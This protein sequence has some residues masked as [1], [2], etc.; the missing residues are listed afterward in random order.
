MLISSI[1]F[2]NRRRSEKNRR[3]KGDVLKDKAQDLTYCKKQA[4]RI[5]KLK[6]WIQPQ[7]ETDL[8]RSGS[9]TNKNDINS[10]RTSGYGSSASVTSYGV[11]SSSPTPL[12]DRVSITT[13]DEYNLFIDPSFYFVTLRK[14]K[15]ITRCSS[16]SRRIIRTEDHETGG[17]TQ[18]V[19]LYLSCDPNY[20][21]ISNAQRQLELK[22]F[23]DDDVTLE[24]DERLFTVHESSTGQTFIQP[25]QHKGYYLHH[26]DD[27]LSVTKLELHLRP[28]EEYVFY[29]HS[30]GNTLLQSPVNTCTHD[31]T[32]LQSSI[33]NKHSESMHVQS[34]VTKDN[35]NS[36]V[37]SMETKEQ[38]RYHDRNRCSCDCVSLTESNNIDLSDLNSDVIKL[39]NVSATVVHH[40]T[41]REKHK[42][43]TV[44]AKR[45]SFYNVVSL[46]GSCFG[47]RQKTQD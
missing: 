38:C 5:S 16:F 35:N 22:L 12:T 41:L 14:Q 23:H 2:V 36:I 18:T 11:T 45:S 21:L 10:P 15:Q 37:V 7:E 13:V 1:N 46:T 3:E 28:P 47:F 33:D 6:N 30:H 24:E 39:G 34:S 27:K 19:Q 42:E 26:L 32:R 31:N 4:E 44:Q 20:F 40:V 29:V 8:L 25:Y 43:M 17:R 9:R